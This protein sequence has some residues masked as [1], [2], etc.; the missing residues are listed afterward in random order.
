MEF[1]FHNPTHLIFGAGTLS[2]LG[3]VAGKHGKM[4][5]I[6]TGGG[7]VKRNGTLNALK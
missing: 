3:E 2:R 7:S 5:L 4:A 6:V 1:E